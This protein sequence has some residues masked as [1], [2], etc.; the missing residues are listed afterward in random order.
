MSSVLVMVW[1]TALAGPPATGQAK[2]PQPG[3]V[4]PAPLSPAEAARRP[5]EKTTAQ[6]DAPARGV[7]DVAG[8]FKPDAIKEANRIVVAIRGDHDKDLLIE[9]FPGVP[10]DRKAAYAKVKGDEEKRE[11]VFEEWSAERAKAAGVSGIYVLVTRSPGHLHI[12]VGNK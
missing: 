11:Q 3:G 10:E 1:M 8:F 7:R 9:T 2:R 12:T 5:A 4:P 6:A